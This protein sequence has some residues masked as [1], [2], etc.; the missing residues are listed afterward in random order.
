MI[1]RLKQNPVCSVDCQTNVS[2]FYSESSQSKLYLSFLL[3]VYTSNLY[4]PDLSY[5]ESLFAVLCEKREGG[6]GRA[7][8]LQ[9]IA[10]LNFNE[11]VL[12]Q[13]VHFYL[14]RGRAGSTGVRVP[15]YLSLNVTGFCKRPIYERFSH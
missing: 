10:T 14:M 8:L 12:L 15:R 3:D 7:K 13:S 6:E 9:N 5:Y 1:S 4:N 11:C 2:E